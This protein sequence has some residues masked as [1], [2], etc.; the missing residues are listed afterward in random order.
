MFIALDLLIFCYVR[1]II[2]AV[3][4]LMETF[5]ENVQPHDLGFNML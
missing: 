1:E 5:L 2:V 4:R 3:S